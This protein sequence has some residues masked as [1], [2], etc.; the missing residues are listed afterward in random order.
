MVINN[1]YVDV[2]HLLCSTEILSALLHVDIRNILDFA[3]V[4]TVCHLKSVLLS[5]NQQDYDSPIHINN[6][7]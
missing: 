7:V 5:L 6:S 1:T 3:T 2:L 4:K